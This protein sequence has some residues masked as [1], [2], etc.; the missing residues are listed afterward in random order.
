MQDLSAGAAAV[1]V[2]PRGAS[3]ALVPRPLHA[4]LTVFR[5]AA[6]AQCPYRRWCGH[7]KNLA[8]E[9]KRAATALKG[10]AK[11]VALD[12]SSG[13]S[14]A[15]KF[16]VQGF[17]TIKIFGANKRSPSDYNGAR[18]SDDIVDAVMKEV[19]ALVPKHAGKKAAGGSSGSKQRRN[20]DASQPGGGKQVVS[21]TDADFDA[22]VM[23]SDEPWLVEFYAPWCGHCKS[24]APEWAAAAEALEGDVNVA[25]VD[26]TQHAAIASRFGVRGYPTIKYIPAGASSD[27]DVQDYNGGRDASSITQ[28]AQARLQA[29]GG[30]AG[31]PVELTSQAVFDKECKKQRIC[32]ITLL[33]HIATEGKERREARLAT[34]QAAIKASGAPQFRLLWTSEAQQPAVEEAFGMRGSLPSVVAVSRSKKAFARH[35]GPVDEAGIGS[36]LSGLVSGRV[37]PALAK[38]G[39]PAIATVE[40]WDG[41]D[42]PEEEDDIDLEELLGE[43]L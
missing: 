30:S 10:V 36:F 8:P 15:S 33:P 20:A 34:M 2:A 43:S 41:Q 17:P 39:L 38:G 16:G 23:G 32:I 28:W 11:V 24:L 40:P 22:R 21:L 35:R 42:A 25:A 29:E 31:G 27:A 13:S 5:R 12:A 14:M 9:W 4:C 6:G 18:T 1:G 37:R 7:C 19:R 26:A 3:P